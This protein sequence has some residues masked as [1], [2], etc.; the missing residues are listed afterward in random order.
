MRA[1]FEGS[2]K[3]WDAESRDGAGRGYVAVRDEDEAA[4]PDD[5]GEGT[6][7]ASGEPALRVSEAGES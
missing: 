4:S 6:A 7:L 1:L 3:A 2:G 5:E